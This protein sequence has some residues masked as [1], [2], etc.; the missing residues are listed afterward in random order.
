[1]NYKD[2]ETYR[3][4]QTVLGDYADTFIAQLK[5]LLKGKRA[6]CVYI[7]SGLP[8]SGKSSLLSWYNDFIEQAKIK[9]PAPTFELTCGYR[10]S[11]PVLVVA[12]DRLKIH[13]DFI[14]AEEND[15]FIVPIKTKRVSNP[16]NLDRVYAELPLFV[17]LLRDEIKK[18]QSE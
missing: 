6:G 8:E 7:I 14:A 16:P 1:M 18:E 17:M 5:A 9:L 12:D 4:L 15:S 11:M 13:S 2:F 3:F 10:P